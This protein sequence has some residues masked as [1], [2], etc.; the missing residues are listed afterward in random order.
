MENAFHHYRNKN[1]SLQFKKLPSGKGP[2]LKNWYDVNLTNNE[3][4]NI[5]FQFLEV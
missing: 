5:P 1:L 2:N 3:A 4:R